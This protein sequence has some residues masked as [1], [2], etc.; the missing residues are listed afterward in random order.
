MKTQI[1]ALSIVSAADIAVVKPDFTYDW[2]ISNPKAFQDILHEFG[3]DVT[4]MWEVQDDVIHTT[5]MNKV[6]QCTRY[7]GSERTDKEWINSGYASREAKDK[8]SGSKLLND[9]YRGKGMTE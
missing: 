7:V 2:T 1:I 5:R 3:M 9:I 6:V 8:S 4:S